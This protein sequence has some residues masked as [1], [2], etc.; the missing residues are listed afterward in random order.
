MHTSERPADASALD[1]TDGSPMAVDQQSTPVTDEQSVHTRRDQRVK[2]SKCEKPRR[3]VE[4]AVSEMVSTFM[5]RAHYDIVHLPVCAL[6]PS[7]KTLR[8][9]AALSQMRPAGF[10][11]HVR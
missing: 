1:P 3:G 9:C 7:C 5:P 2:K 8:C 10:E 6:P 4:I 11:R